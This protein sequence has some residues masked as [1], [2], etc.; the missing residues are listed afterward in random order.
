MLCNG[1]QWRYILR[2]HKPHYTQI[3]P[4]QRDPT[5]RQNNGLSRHG[6]R[7]NNRYDVL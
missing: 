5:Q 3:Q 2:F 4:H 1:D 6:T 7:P